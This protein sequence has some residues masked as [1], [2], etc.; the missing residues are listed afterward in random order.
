[1]LMANDDETLLFIC[2]KVKVKVKNSYS[3]AFVKESVTG[4]I[5]IIPQ[6][7]AFAHPLVYSPSVSL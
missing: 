4:R 6:V 5:T 1:M 7:D 3:R 2:L